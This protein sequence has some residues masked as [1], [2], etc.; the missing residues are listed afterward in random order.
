MKTIVFT[1]L[2]IFTYQFAVAQYNVTGN[3]EDQKGENLGFANVLLLNATDST[4]VVGAT[5]D[6]NGKFILS[7]SQSGDFLLSVSM[8]GFTTYYSE[9]FN[10]NSENMSKSFLKIILQEGG[11]ELDAVTITAEKP[12]FERKI[13]RT[14]IN[15]E[16]RVITA[17]ATAL[18]VLE[19]SP[20]VIVDRNS[21]SL[22][23]MGRDG[24]NVMIN[25]RLTYMPMDALMQFLDGMSADNII[26]IELITTPPARFDA[27]GNAGYINLVLKKNPNDG[28]NGN[29]SVTAGYG[30]GE[31]ANGSINFNY[32]KN[33]IN[34]FGGY[35]Y[36]RNAQD[37]EFFFN[38]D[39]GVG[40]DLISTRTL[41]TRDPLQSNHN[42][43]L[44]L[45]FEVTEKTT[46]GV[47]FSGYD[48]RWHMDAIND[49]QLL[50]SIADTFSTIDMV[51]DN[52]WQHLQANINLAHEFK[53]GGKLNFDLDYLTYANENPT[54]YD[55]A[56]NDDN[57]DLIS[58]E[59]LFSTKTTPFTIRVA[60]LDYE[61]N[62][63]EKLQLSGGAKIVQSDFENDVEIRENNIVNPDFT[64]LSNL[65]ENVYAA[66][67][68]SRFQATEKL[69]MQLGL[70]YEFT[71]TDLESSTEGKVV[72]RE[73]GSLF[74]TFYLDYKLND[75][76]Q[77]NLSYSRRINRPSF[78]NMAP[79][80]I[81]VDP[82]TLFGGNAA[83]QPAITNTLE[84]GYRFKT[85]NLTM[86][87]SREDSSIA[88]FQSQFDVELNRQ[89]IIPINLKQQDMFVTSLSFP[90]KVTDWWNMRL[91]GMYFWTQTQ[92]VDN[93]G[94]FTLSQ[95][96]FRLNG[97]QSFTLPKGFNIELSGFYTSPFING[98]FIIESLW[99]LNFGLSKQL[100][101]GRIAFNIGDIFN[102]IKSTGIV[103]L[104]TQ[105]IYSERGFDFS[106]RTFRLTFSSSFGNQKVKRA[107]DRNSSDEERSRV[108]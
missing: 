51:E 74:P 56:F 84:V 107:R 36:S 57:G 55:L 4:F 33:K 105:N 9:S 24:V 67:A 16:N 3:L 29:Y 7:T 62:I 63:N 58:N 82:N 69:G 60:Q 46:I 91:F 99:G 40:T 86:Q 2:S 83:L 22:S 73:F 61:K 90:V 45:D 95:S 98:N 92:T 64:S 48:N 108:N 25:G 103:D 8:I 72:D 31:V 106:Q 68:Q 47:L 53:N 12:L 97:T 21:N 52:N 104:P 11:I 19:R 101:N 39:I 77:T 44:G 102:S 34:L 50:T 78:S 42:G 27:E 88:R 18:E 28:L 32:R 66:Y 71:D 59:T 94:E 20:M 10:L 15:L 49:G 14:V 41:S 85:V 100:K 96:T 80:I 76:N 38:S 23:M 70:R 17:G 1:I 37:Q 26:S 5:T 81:F 87:Y 6:S 65:T 30:R 43:R 79:F 13:D 93:L 89:V 54:D 35:N 75:N